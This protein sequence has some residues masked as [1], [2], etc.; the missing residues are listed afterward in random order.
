[1]TVRAAR[2]VLLIPFNAIAMLN[3]GTAAAA[4]GHTSI[5]KMETDAAHRPGG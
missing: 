4:S 5:R 1:M 2:M 3:A